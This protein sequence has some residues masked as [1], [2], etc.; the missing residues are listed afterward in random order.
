MNII[1]T[2]KYKKKTEK[3]KIVRKS[4][5]ANTLSQLCLI[6]TNIQ[7]SFI[8]RYYIEFSFYLHLIDTSQKRFI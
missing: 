6:P 8:L 5:K 7:V 3:I 4:S 2:S 1:K